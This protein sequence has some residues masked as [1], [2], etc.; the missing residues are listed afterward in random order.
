[1]NIV[2]NLL[3]FCLV[4]FLY[5]HIYFHL[6]TSD[7]LEMYEIEQPSKEKLEEICDLRQ[8]LLFDYNNDKIIDVFK[9][10]N[11]LDT[12]GA[13]DIKIRNVKTPDYDTDIYLPIVFNNAINVIK[14][15]TEQKYISENNRDFIDETTL[16]KNFSYNDV[17]LRPHMVANCEYDYMF[18]SKDSVTPFRYEINYRNYFLVTEGKAVIRLTPFK[19]SKYL[20][21]NNDYEN[22]EFRS[23]INPWDVL[24]IYK[25][26][27]DKIKCLDIEV[28][29]GQILYIP[30]YWYYSIK[31]DNETSICVF[32]YRTYMNTFAILPQL[33][34]NVLQ[35]QNIK[36]QYTKK[37]ESDK[38]KLTTND[39][40]DDSNINEN[41]ENKQ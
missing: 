15:D 35:N 16:F 12:Y 34:L 41:K 38:D 31:F 20:H 22:L 6:K 26:D 39:K 37:V 28:K 40:K 7:D 25:A 14:N 30:A 11:I 27:F 33:I 17:F 1:M 19:S 32:K 29:P 10:S 36:R 13:F 4:L 2:I 21:T 24:P 9:Q 5:L 8:P 18:G 3:I 23:E